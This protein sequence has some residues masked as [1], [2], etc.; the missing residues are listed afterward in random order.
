MPYYIKYYLFIHKCNT[1]DPSIK[2]CKR[3]FRK[4]DKQKDLTLIKYTNN[5][6]LVNSLKQFVKTHPNEPIGFINE[7]AKIIHNLTLLPDIPNLQTNTFPNELD[8]KIPNVFCLHANITNIIYNSQFNTEYWNEITCNE[9]LNFIVAPRYMNTLINCLDTH[10]TFTSTRELF[11]YFTKTFTQTVAIT[12]YNFTQDKTLW[13]SISD[14]FFSKSTSNKEKDKLLT[15]YHKESQHRLITLQIPTKDPSAITNYY[16][17]LDSNTFYKYTPKITVIMTLTDINQFFVTFHSFMKQDYPRNKIELYILDEFKLDTKLKHLIPPESRI[18]FI[19]LQTKEQKKIPLGYKLNTGFK[20][21]SND[22]VCVML[23]TH[24]YSPD[25]L[26]NHVWNLLDR[27]QS[28]LS[29]LVTHQNTHPDY[30]IGSLACYKK[31]WNHHSFQELQDNPDTL[32]LDFLRYRTSMCNLSESKCFQFCKINTF[33][34]GTPHTPFTN[35]SL[36]V[37]EK[38]KIQDDDD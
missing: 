16:K 14:S 3:K 29:K 20:Y 23:D 6:E 12:Q 17:T 10:T 24:Y 37:Y 34:S 32:L 15:Q 9:S 38:C 31:F 21:A 5:K 18:R 7:D 13:T 11:S 28:N 19:N 4:L 33:S 26:S 30:D 1:S 36:E 8:N 22:I 2:Q 27:N 35:E 25:Y